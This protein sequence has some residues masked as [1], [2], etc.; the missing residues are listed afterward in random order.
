M[1]YLVLARKYRPQT[2]E[3]VVKQEHIT[4]TLTNAITSGRVAHAILFSGPRGTGKTTVAR[5]LAKAMN[6]SDNKE[7]GPS[8]VPCNSCRSC[9]EI[10]AGHASDVFEIDGAS[11]NSVDQV[12]E[13]R[14]NIKYMPA[15]SPHKIYIIDE[16]HM[17]SLAA[18]NALLKTLEEPPAHVLFLFATTDP[19]KI[20]ITIL[21][22]CQRHDL[23]RIDIDSVAKHMEWMCSKENGEIS[24][25]SLQLIA[26]ESGGSMRD[27]LSLLDQIMSC[28]DGEITHERVLNILGVVDRKIIFDISSAIL[29]REITT[30]LDV[31]DN[32]YNR[33]HD[34]IKLYSTLI[35]H[36]RNL[37]IVKMGREITKLVDVPEHEHKKMAVQVE[38]ISETYLT[39]IL[40]ILFREESVIKYSTMPK[41]AFETIFIKIFQISPALSID[42]LIS[43]I[44]DLT[45]GVFE[46]V[47][48]GSVN[49]SNRPQ[50]APPK[51]NVNN[52]QNRRAPNL[53]PNTISEK[54]P[55]KYQGAPVA[56]N[57]KENEIVKEEVVY[58]KFIK[59][60]SL[61]ENWTSYINILRMKNPSLVPCLE[62]CTLKKV[63]EESIE[64]D[65]GGNKFNYERLKNDKNLTILKKTGKIFFEKPVNIILNAQLEEYESNQKKQ[66]KASRLKQSALAHPVVKDALEIFNGKVIDFRT[67]KEN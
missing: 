58:P 12:R 67:I 22:R 19:Q 20:P 16:V 34:I 33:G 37:L 46:P 59:N 64:I 18:F 31:I 39:Q 42:T 65:V 26:Q 52:N 38:K 47:S 57:K 30:L 6:C 32:L 3:E 51:N 21:S 60:Q 10:T 56:P 8:A 2:F 50:A 14:E 25:E 13:L 28:S 63:S 43:K 11:N 29:N 23:R 15:H 49:S 41:I 17:L 62:K 55:D 40:D 35:E 27:A 4:K 45:N 54:A 66:E 48:T 61:G 44:D 1:S 24:S 9:K 36:F 5:I 7:N 53:K